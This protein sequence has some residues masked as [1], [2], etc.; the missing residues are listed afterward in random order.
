MRLFLI[1]WFC[2]LLSFNAKA[3]VSFLEGKRNGSLTTIPTIVISGNITKGDI[4]K[5]DLIV[6]E[7]HKNAVKFGLLLLGSKYG[8]FGIRL[9]S[10]GGDVAAAMA[11]GYRIREVGAIVRVERGASCASS[12]VLLLAAG[13]RRNVFGKVGIHRPYSVVDN[14]LTAQGQKDAYKNVARLINEY[15]E[16]MNI[17]QDLYERMLRIPPESIHWL[18][19]SEMQAYGLNED[20]PYVHEASNAGL[21][22]MFGLSKQQYLGALA[23]SKRSCGDNEYVNCLFDLIAKYKSG[24]P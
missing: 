20:D 6:P 21:A 24:S 12:C 14:A 17:S 7:A 19:N 5:F 23:E 22:K 4:E 2:T 16:N 1:C 11:I 10:P 9:D 18:S 15:L 8:I 13:Q 3:E